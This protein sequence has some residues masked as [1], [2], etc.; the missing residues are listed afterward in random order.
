MNKKQAAKTTK[1]TAPNTQYE[2][3]IGP[4]K[5]TNHTP[6]PLGIIP[7]ITRLGETSR[8]IAAGAD[9]SR[10]SLVPEI[11]TKSG[12]A[13]LDNGDMVARLFRGLDT[14]AVLRAT[15]AR[16]EALTGE[17]VTADGLRLKYGHLN[18]GQIR[19]N[20]GNR[21]RAAV[22]RAAKEETAE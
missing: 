9:I 17:P 15:A 16:L 22:K 3:P 1:P 2:A 10:W 4:T 5:P 21:V 11:R 7:T 12:R 6:K 18:P 20:C 19:M 13:T 14:D 8:S